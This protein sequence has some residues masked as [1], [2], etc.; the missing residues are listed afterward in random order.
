MRFGTGVK[1]VCVCVRPCVCVHSVCTHAHLDGV[2]NSPQCQ[3]YICGRVVQVGSLKIL[4]G[5][6]GGE[7][8]RGR[9]G[10]LLMHEGRG[11]GSAE[12]SCAEEECRLFPCVGR[13][14]EPSW[15]QAGVVSPNEKSCVG[16][17]G[18]PRYCCPVAKR[19]QS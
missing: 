18:G 16:D 5:A 9:E 19:S 8:K 7:R 4:E 2:W 17:G 6:A 1:Y 11:R 3:G 10:G 12:Q 15:Q 13:T 14:G